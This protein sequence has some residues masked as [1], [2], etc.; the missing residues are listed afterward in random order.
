MNRMTL[1][2][3]MAVTAL[4][5]GACGHRQSDRALSGAAIGA[6]AGAVAA[7]GAGRA[8]AGARTRT[9][10]PQRSASHSM[11]SFGVC[12]IEGAQRSTQ[13]MAVYPRSSPK[14]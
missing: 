1:P 3:V 5:L 7:W 4:T 2:V 14:S 12:A 11:A 10:T 9:S 13:S 6:G 8:A